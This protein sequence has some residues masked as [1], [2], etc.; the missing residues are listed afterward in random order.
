MQWTTK[1]RMM[2]RWP[3]MA[4]GLV[5]ALLATLTIALT[6]FDGGVAIVWIA[7]GFLIPWMSLTRR[8][9]WGRAI[10]IGL[11]GN[12]VATIVYGVGWGGLGLPVLNLTE[13]VVTVEILRRWLGHRYYMD[14][15]GGFTKFVLVATLA[16]TINAPIA[17]AFAHFSLGVP[18]WA[19]AFNWF[20]GH[21]LGVIIVAPLA[22]LTL[23]MLRAHAMP[24]RSTRRALLLWLGPVALTAALV[25]GQQAVQLL[26]LPIVPMM[27]ATLRLG[28]LGAA[29][30]VVILAAIAMV[31]TALDHG[32]ILAMAGG[33]VG[34]AQLLQFYLACTVTTLLPVAVLMRQRRALMER[35]ATSESTL[36][37]MAENSGDALLHVSAQGRIVQATGAI[38]A[39]LGRDTEWLLGRYP[40]DL[41]VAEDRAGVS[42]AHFRLMDS[43]GQ[44]I[45][46]EYRTQMPDGSERWLESRARAIFDDEGRPIGT[47][48]AIRDI[49]SRKRTETELERAASTDQLTGISNRRAFF[50]RFDG[51]P[52]D[53]REGILIVADLD[54]FKSIN[55]RFGH[56]VGDVALQTYSGV[57][58]GQIR[59]TDLIARIGGEEFAFYLPGAGLDEG[60]ALYNR[61][62]ASLGQA[63]FEAGK[64]GPQTI[65]ASMGMVAVTTADDAAT[66]LKR[67]DTAL[68][69]AKEAGRDC[70]R[71]AA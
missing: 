22:S 67:A 13:C 35:L 38:T 6:R 31:A 58:R 4:A 56:H 18:Y 29:L 15:T 30:S 7:N 43:P 37:M 40:K 49:D 1:I 9:H 46:F 52:D 54:H 20:A 66:A 33:A 12:M 23:R 34:K 21:A 24:R 25:F 19:T 10:L 42:T 69:A 11:I 36:R 27:L 5:Y 70:L 41:V 44:A 57:A 48:S 59:E 45:N 14:S 50:A 26:F 28:R 62:R 16:P 53:Q 65:T 63:T 32:P 60:Y 55:D 64:A 3:G 71:L 39:L 68:Y 2:A 17:A 61:L 47:I 8:R 51:R